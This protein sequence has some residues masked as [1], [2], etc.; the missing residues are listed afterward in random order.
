MR[1][2]L[3]PVG[4]V[5]PRGRGNLQVPR[6]LRKGLSFHGVLGGVLASWW[7]FPTSLRRNVVCEPGTGAHDGSEVD[8]YG[9]PASRTS[10][11]TSSFRCRIRPQ[12]AL[13]CRSGR[14]RHL[15]AGICPA[16]RRR[17]RQARPVVPLVAR[18]SPR[19]RGGPDSIRCRAHP[20]V[21]A[22]ASSPHPG[23]HEKVRPGGRAV[24]QGTH[25][26]RSVHSGP[27]S[28][29]HAPCDD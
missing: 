8:N 6:I 25:L 7:V 14:P 4:V 17:R 23:A 10:S 12:G 15:G 19:E 13:V 3:W 24:P 2:G 27:L 28:L 20:F 5:M 9:S 29:P 18:R 21:A 26:H 1:S 11:R 22:D 16:F